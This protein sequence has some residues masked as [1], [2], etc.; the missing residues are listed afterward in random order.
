MAEVAIRIPI[1]LKVVVPILIPSKADV[2][3][4]IYT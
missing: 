4:H 1:T 2:T 3:V